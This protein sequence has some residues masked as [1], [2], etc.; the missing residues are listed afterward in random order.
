M[1]LKSY[2]YR[3]TFAVTM[4]NFAAEWWSDG[5]W[6]IR[7]EVLRQVDARMLNKSLPIC[8]ATDERMEELFNRHAAMERAPA[9]LGDE[10]IYPTNGRPVFDEQRAVRCGDDVLLNA[11]IVKFLQL[12]VPEVSFRPAVDNPGFNAVAIMSG[13]DMVGFVMPLWYVPSDWS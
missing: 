2:R 10:V 12:R 5:H 4:S 8:R 3:P 13:D 6:M 7:R 11:D 9:E 1:K